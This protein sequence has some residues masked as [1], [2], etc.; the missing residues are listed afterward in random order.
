MRPAAF[1]MVRMKSF[2]V[3]I[4]LCLLTAI[5][6]NIQGQ[7]NKQ[8]YAD[9]I[10]AVVKSHVPTASRVKVE[11]QHMGVLSGHYTDLPPGMPALG[12]DDLYLFPDN[13]YFYVEWTD[14]FPI[15]ITDRGTWSYKD[16]LI[17]LYSDKTLP[18]GEGRRNGKFLPLNIERDGK[19][20]I[21]LLGAEGDF[22]Y[23]KANAKANDEFMLILCTYNQTDNFVTKDYEQTKTEVYD[24]CWRPE[25]VK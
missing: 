6:G 19:R 24:R 14:V 12:Y 20:L 9:R 3:Q 2:Q 18:K 17:V 23:F 7:V 16:G 11:L 22:A 8:S 15:T 5:V 13:T 25:R 4:Y 21:L 10:F 1:K